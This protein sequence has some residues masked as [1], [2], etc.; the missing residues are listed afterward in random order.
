MIRAIF[1]GGPNHG[2]KREF[3]DREAPIHIFIPVRE[4]RSGDLRHAVYTRTWTKTDGLEA[5]HCTDTGL[6]PKKGA[7]RGRG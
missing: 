5:Y 6:T 1:V 3:P 4:P 2:E 7:H